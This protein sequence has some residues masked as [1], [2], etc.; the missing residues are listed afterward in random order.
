MT[1]GRTLLLIALVAAVGC[2]GPTPTQPTPLIQS[3]AP[4]PSGPPPPSPVTNYE[5]TGIVTDEGGAPMPGVVVTMAHYTGAEV[6]S[7]RWPTVSSDA[8][9]HYRI[10]FT[11]YLLGGS[12]VA[13]AQVAADGYEE[14]WRSLRTDGRTTFVLN[15]RL[16]RLTRIAAGESTVLSVLPDDGDCRSYSFMSGVCGVVRITISQAGR[17][18]VQVVSDDTMPAPQLEICCESGNGVVG[19][20]VTLNVTPGP[21]L[22][23]LIGLGQAVSRTRS[24]KVKTTL[25]AF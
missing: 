7:L 8:S 18:T 6:D 25:E 3:A 14:Y 20:P 21:E 13:R 24:F 12:F 4:G 16:S 22:V 19:N 5:V 1:S 9:G 17:L 10:G 23:L 2:D 15:V 11:P